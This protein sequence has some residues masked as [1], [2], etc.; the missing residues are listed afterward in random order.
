[1]RILAGCDENAWTDVTRIS[2][3]MYQNVWLV[4]DAGFLGFGKVATSGAKG[5]YS[6]T[7]PRREAANVAKSKKDKS[8]YYENT[9]EVF[10]L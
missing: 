1:M 10:I 9:Q 6:S 7:K 3:R 5:A 2:G 8:E 4:P